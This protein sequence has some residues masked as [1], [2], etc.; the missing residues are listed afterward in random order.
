MDASEHLAVLLHLAPG[1]GETYRHWLQ[2]NSAKV[3][4]QGSATGLRKKVVLA[5]GS[6]IV[7][8]LEGVSAGDLAEL[9]GEAEAA[10]RGTGPVAAFL[11]VARP[12]MIMEQIFAWRTPDPRTRTESAGLVLTLQDGKLPE[13]KE[14]LASDV[15]ATLEEIWRRDA[16]WRHDVLVSGH[17]VVAYYEC[18][19]RF[20]V[21]RA[22]REPEALALLFGDLGKLMVLDPYVPTPLFEELHVWEGPGV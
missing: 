13:Y 8:S 15:I 5:N 1:Q 17:T 21:L 18:E 2:K 10:A 6:R 7:V 9:P 22:F 4:S 20:N 16:I 14:W 12:P 19:E 3:D 11:D